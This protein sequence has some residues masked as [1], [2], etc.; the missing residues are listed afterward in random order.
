[1]NK[2]KHSVFVYVRLSVNASAMTNDFIRSTMHE[3][4]VCMSLVCVCIF[5]CSKCQSTIYAITAHYID[6]CY[7]MYVQ[8]VLYLISNV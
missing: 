7:V 3:K 5:M 4:T 2:L 6:F 8:I 1:M